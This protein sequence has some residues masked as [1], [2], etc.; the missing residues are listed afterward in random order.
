MQ[1]FRSWYRFARNISQGFSMRPCALFSSFLF[2]FTTR[3]RVES[4]SQVCQKAPVVLVSG[5]HEEND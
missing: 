1:F 2:R 4:V 5:Y 3:R